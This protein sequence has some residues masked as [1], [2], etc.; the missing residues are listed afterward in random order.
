MRLAALVGI[1]LTF[2]CATTKPPPGLFAVF[3][4]DVSRA[5]VNHQACGQGTSQ[6]CSTA[7]AV[8]TEEAQAAAGRLLPQHTVLTNET[9]LALLEENGIDVDKACEASCALQGA[10]EIKAT[11]FLSSQLL[12]LD[13]GQHWYLRLH[14]SQTGRQLTSLRLSALTIE[15]LQRSFQAQAPELFQPLMPPPPFRWKRVHTGYTVAA[16]A[17][18]LGVGSYLSYSKA[19]RLR[20]SMRSEDLPVDLAQREA[21]IAEGRRASGWGFALASGAVLAGG[22]ATFI[23]VGSF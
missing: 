16:T 14:E 19:V 21:L 11:A 6:A 13:D 4:P 18:V 5:V 8:L 12:T 9:T 10:R 20:D 7:R 15:G 3:P 22:A 23:I 2:G 17:V 1:A